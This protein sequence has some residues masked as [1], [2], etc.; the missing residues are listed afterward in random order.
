MLQCTPG[1]RLYAIVALCLLISLTCAQ[2]ETTSRRPNSKKPQG[3]VI[4]DKTVHLL[5]VVKVTEALQE[6]IKVVA[7]H[8]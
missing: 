5:P 4:P 7:S 2:E 1:G 6:R 8:P 3:G